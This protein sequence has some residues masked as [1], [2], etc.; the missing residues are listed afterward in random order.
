MGLLDGIL[1]AVSGGAGGGMTQMI[2][3][4]AVS[5]IAAKLGMDPTMAQGIASS[6]MSNMAAGHAPDA[7]VAAA[8]DE[9]GVDADHVGQI[10]DA[11]AGHAGAEGGL[12][13]LVNQLGGPQALLG[14]L[15]GAAGGA[16]GAAGLAG[17]LGGLMGGNKA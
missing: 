4:A 7:A 13:G 6:L 15:G 8:A 1:G 3:G 14:M 16:G 17:M 5:A 11:L 2:E 12:G 9:H 10:G